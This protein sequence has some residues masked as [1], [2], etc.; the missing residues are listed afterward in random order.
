MM[1]KNSFFPIIRKK[2]PNPLTWKKTAYKNTFFAKRREDI[3][4][5]CE[6]ID[7]K[8]DVFIKKI[9]KKTF[10]LRMIKIKF[11]IRRS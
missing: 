9:R 5:A 4:D 2:K 6:K 10:K 11:H 8:N 3:N 7:K 1:F